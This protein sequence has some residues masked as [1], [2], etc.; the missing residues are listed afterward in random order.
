MKCL[1]CDEPKPVYR[2]SVGEYKLH[3]CRNCG[4]RFHIPVPDVSGA[5]EWAEKGYRGELL[6]EAVD[7]FDGCY[8]TLPE[9]PLGKEYHDFLDHYE[10]LR[11]RG[12]LLDV[13]SG[14]GLFLAVA[15]ERGWDVEGV[16]FCSIPA[17]T[18]AEKFGIAPIRDAF[19][20][21]DWGD[22]RFD[23]VTIW[24]TL[25]HLRNPLLTVRKATEILKPGG[26][27]FLSIPDRRSLIYLTSEIL[28]KFGNA[29]PREKLYHPAHIGYFDEN[30]IR[31]IAEKTGLKLAE[32]RREN[33]Q[34]N[35]YRLGAFQKLSLS[36]LNGL[37]SLTGRQSRLLILAEKL[38]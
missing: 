15:K 2:F 19:E 22:K 27:I 10:R 5:R 4:F 25:E 1:I 17:E 12:K 35:R 23:L 3:E 26:H 20:E 36:T 33:P 13:G 34:L 21:I 11:P 8:S 38:S 37:A 29:G 31:V 16:E 30:V 9:N 18:S 28:A 6:S 7:M 14:V 24:D 32:V